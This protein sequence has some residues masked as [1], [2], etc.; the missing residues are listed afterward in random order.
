MR[1]PAHSTRRGSRSRQSGR[2]A[3]V[4]RSSIVGPGDAVQHA[5][6]TNPFA[7]SLTPNSQSGGTMNYDESALGQPE[8]PLDAGVPPPNRP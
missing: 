2:A 7:G 8:P 4:D 3:S 6:G 5:G 1:R